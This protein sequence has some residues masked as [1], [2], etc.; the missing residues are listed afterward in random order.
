MRPVD[1]SVA[2]VRQAL[3]GHRPRLLDADAHRKMAA[4]AAVLRE[5]AG[6]GE[7]LFI[8]RAEHPADPW[9]GH[10]AFPGGRVEAGDAEPLAAAVRETREEV[11]LDLT[12][13]GTHLGRLSD[14]AAI[15][16][17][18]PLPLVIAPFVFALGEPL[19]LTPNDEVQ[20]AVWVPLPF[21]AD[22]ANRGTMRWRYHGLPVP[23]PCYRF[24]GR[25]IWGLT[26][27]MVDEL[28]SCLAKRRPRPATLL[29]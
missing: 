2:A 25:L 22:R 3:A 16:R 19:E 7:L 26:L 17:G 21:L 8:H 18:R 13:S 24:E 6:G 11:G 23:L 14:V 4:V 20:E 10:M 28:L 12:A 27:K 15:G 1:L 29:L 9:S 5:G